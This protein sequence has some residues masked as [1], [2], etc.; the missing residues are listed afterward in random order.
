MAIRLELGLSKFKVGVISWLLCFSVCYYFA[1]TSHKNT[2]ETNLFNG[3][4]TCILVLAC[5]GLNASDRT[6]FVTIGKIP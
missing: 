5:F 1:M 3:T 6:P 4:L 2:V